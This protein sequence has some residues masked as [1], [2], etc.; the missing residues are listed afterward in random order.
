[1]IIS[2]LER[3]C[4][5]P[6]FHFASADARICSH[7]SVAAGCAWLPEALITRTSC[8]LSAIRP[9]SSALHTRDEPLFQVTRNV[10]MMI[11]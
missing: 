9:S 4:Y 3:R 11:Q 1:M 5:L 7:S 6:S 10:V 8:G 2:R